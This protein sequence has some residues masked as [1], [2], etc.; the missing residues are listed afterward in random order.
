MGATTDNLCLGM[1][2]VYSFFGVTLAV[3]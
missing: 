1:A 2:A 3:A